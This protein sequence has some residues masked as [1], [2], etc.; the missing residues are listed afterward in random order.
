MEGS[1]YVKKFFCAAAL[2]ALFSC[3]S[4]KPPAINAGEKQTGGGLS[5]SG[6]AAGEGA[7]PRYSLQVIPAEATRKTVLK[8]VALGFKVNDARIEW[9]LNGGPVAGMGD[10]FTP[11]A[12]TKGDKVQAR[13]FVGEAEVSSEAIEIK[14]SPPE[15]TRVK[16]MPEVFK[17]GDKINVEAAA[18]DADND[19]VAISYEW[20]KN[21]EPAGEGK[22]MELPLK[23]G[24]IISVKVTPF[25]GQAYGESALLKRE[26]KNMPPVITED[27]KFK[28]SG[29]N[30]SHQIEAADPDGDTLAYSLKSAPPGM[31]VDPAKGLITWDVPRGF[32][33]KAT[34]VAV[35][36]DGHGGEASHTFIVTINP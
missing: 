13:A 27:Y 4:E 5:A 19:E 1:G 35:V 10:T 22:T 11:S 31:E 14:N 34:V 3:S 30:W 2:I 24:D 9:I 20:T 15:L 29:R 7:Q 6:P 28:T 23:R 18:E 26:I 32:H 33:G 21:G 17:P 25:D 12:T 8:A 16:I 36:N